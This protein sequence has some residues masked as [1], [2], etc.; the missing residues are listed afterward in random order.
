MEVSNQTNRVE[1][2]AIHVSSLTEKEG[3]VSIVDSEPKRT[4]SNR[5]DVEKDYETLLGIN[6]IEPRRNQP[7]TAFDEGALQELAESIKMYGIIQPLV[8][9]R[10]GER[11]EIIAGE[12]RWR[13]G[14]M[15]GLRKVPVVIRNYSKQEMAEI[16]LIENIQ[17][18]DL[19]PIEEAV[20][21]QRLIQEFHLKQEEL[22]QRVCKSRTAITNSMR[23]LKLDK[24]VQQMIIDNVISNGHGR[25][26]LAI[27]DLELQYVLA[28]KISN[29]KL[30]V[31]ETEH[32]VKKMSQNHVEKKECRKEKEVKKKY[33]F[34]YHDLE[35]KMKA[36]MG[37]KVS[38]HRK[39]NGTG[40]IEIEY[41]SED[42]LDRVIDLL[43]TIE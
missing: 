31:R 19:N 14:R 21:Y 27:E 35:E 23:L 25:T 6:E 8:V 43:M 33:D 37:T 26:L 4:A 11:Y 16:S 36:I 40:K 2:T 41:Y 7:R 9:Q 3:K 28:L 1:T 34:I 39:K 5:F 18:E 32:L 30:S 17:R 12:R 42:D 24:R 13:A 29:E 22:A 15:A 10:N 20:A 38:I